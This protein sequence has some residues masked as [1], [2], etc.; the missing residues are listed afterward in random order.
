MLPDLI[1]NAKSVLLH[2]H[3]KP[4]PDSIGSALAMYHALKGVGKNV[5][6]IKGDSTLPESFSFI[7]GFKDIVLKNYFEINLND[8]DLFIIQDSGSESMISRKGEIVFPDYLKTIVIDHHKT[9]TKFG[10]INYVDSSYSAVA[11]YL[12]DLFKEWGIEITKDIAQCLYIGIYGDTG[13]FRY[14][15]TTTRTMGIIAELARIYPEFPKSI[16]AL[17][18]NNQKEKIYFDAIALG[19]VETFFDGKVAL[20]CIP[21]KTMEE[22]GVT[23]EMSDNNIVAGM[24]L[25]VKDWEIT[26]T[27]IEKA[28][29]EISI[30]FRSK[31]NKD[32]SEVAVSLGGGGHKPASGATLWC[33]LDEAKKK[34][35]EALT[36][37][38]YK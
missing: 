17:E 9:N 6:V 22:K 10:D 36:Q 32:V 12:F 23:R 2:L 20:S 26:G 35:L 28:P 37:V 16:E 4:D 38:I 3:V 1:K 33:S 5:T 24:L 15:T 13:G 25:T 27:L 18:Y 21:F 31:N 29:E 14:V 30:S 34:V 8:F 19:L 7:P 11:E